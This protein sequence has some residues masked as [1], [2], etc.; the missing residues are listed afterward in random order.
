VM[1]LS[2][3]M[4]RAPTLAEIRS[5]CESKTYAPTARYGASGDFTTL[6]KSA[7]P[8]ARDE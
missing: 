2:L 5:R 1:V 8:V 3:A 6:G 7:A 4:T